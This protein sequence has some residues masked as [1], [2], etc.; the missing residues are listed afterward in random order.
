MEYIVTEEEEEEGIANAEI[1]MIT[2]PKLKYLELLCLPNLKSICTG[3]NTIIC[4]SLQEI[5]VLYCPMLKRFP[6][7]T[8]YM[9]GDGQKSKTHPTLLHKITGEQEWW[10]L[11]EWDTTQARSLF[12]PLFSVPQ[13][14]YTMMKDDIWLTDLRCYEEVK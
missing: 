2:F 6:F 9:N 5:R 12:N 10:D 8:M 11:L 13:D 3:M 14:V 4:P 7:S 1:P